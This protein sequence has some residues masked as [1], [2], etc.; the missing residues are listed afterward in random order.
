MSYNSELNT[1]VR[2]KIYLVKLKLDYCGNTF[3]ISPC[4]ATGTPCFNT[5]PTCKDKANYN[6]TTKVYKYVT[7]GIDTKIIDAR[8][9]VEEV[10]FY[11]QEIKDDDTSVGRVKV[12]M[13]DERDYDIGIDP[14]LVNRGYANILDVP[15]NYWKKFIERNKN[16]KSRIIEIYEGFNTLDESEYKLIWAG[17]LTSI[18]INES[19]VT[20]EAED[21]L[22]ALSKVKYPIATS[23]K[24]KDKLKAIYICYSDQDMV[25]TGTWIDVYALRRD[26][27]S[28]TGQGSAVEIT[29]GILLTGTYA[30]YV[31]GYDSYNRPKVKTN[32]IEVLVDNNLGDNAIHLSWNSYTGISYWRVYGSNE[33]YSTEM[34]YYITTTSTQIYV[35]T[36]NDPW[37][38]GVMPEYAERYY[39]LQNSPGSELSNWVPY[40]GIFNLEVSDASLLGSSGYIMVEDEIIYYSSKSGNILSNIKRGQFNT[41][42][43]GHNEDL[44][45][46]IMFN[47]AP[48]NPFNM[49]KGMLQSWIDNN[50]LDV[51]KF[52]N[53]ATS[54]SDINF[55]LKPIIKESKLSDIV[56]DAANMLDCMLY[57]NEEGKITIKKYSEDGNERITD[58][59]IINGSFNYEYDDEGWYTRV[60]IYWDRIKLD[61]SLDD[62]SSYG[63]M[64]MAIDASAESSNEYND[65]KT[66]YYYTAFIS[67]DCDVN[68]KTAEDYVN[69]LAAIL[70]N[71]FRNPLL[72]VNCELEMKDSERI[73][74]GDT[75]L[76]DSN[77]IQD[78]YGNPI[79]GKKFI[80]VKKELMFNKIK[81]KMKE[82]VI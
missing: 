43:K 11:A 67:P 71:R 39:Y 68:G 31:V 47:Y 60:G 34:K 72:V 42:M 74:L 4:T 70:M 51:T 9:Y 45:V 49:L 44:V 36:T 12:T 38:E 23:I 54:W 28:I 24:T 5:F 40:N 27:I 63:R 57:I 8:P 79:T 82:K 65:N 59:D 52:N 41:E 29:G 75:I 55:S 16:Y 3:G 13:V 62:S 33:P 20:L 15:G 18:T 22:T 78:I 48:A 25:N 69:N 77:L 61:E 1:I 10:S 76:L 6:R 19:K 21:M 46:K 58:D 73:K 81:I 14:Y 7:K 80:V 17:K 2:A 56:F 66:K 30:Y 53:Y 37:Y 50:Y 64:N 26:Y 35:G 32:L